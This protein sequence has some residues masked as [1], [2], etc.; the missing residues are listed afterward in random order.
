[1]RHEM[2]ARLTFARL[3]IVATGR[4]IDAF[5]GGHSVASIDADQIAAGATDAE[6]AAEFIYRPILA[7]KL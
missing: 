6:F 3:V 7:V 4:V 5:V 1:M 2:I